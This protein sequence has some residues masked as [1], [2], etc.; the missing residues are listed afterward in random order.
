MIK[1]LV[2]KDRQ[3]YEAQGHFVRVVLDTGDYLEGKCV[4]F[5]SDLENEPEEASIVLKT[6]LKNG[7]YVPGALIEITKSE[8]ENIEFI[9]G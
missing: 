3:M 9:K 4:E 1:P 8:I 7:K 6:P 5:L 2:G